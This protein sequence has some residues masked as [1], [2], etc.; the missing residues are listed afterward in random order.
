MECDEQNPRK[1]PRI[2][3]EEDVINLEQEFNFEFDSFEAMIEHE[4]STETLLE[5]RL[6]IR[7]WFHDHIQLCSI[8]GFLY[9]Y[10]SL[11]IRKPNTPS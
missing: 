3:I 7:W 2:Y 9:S 6:Q 5:G 11:F 4:H 1:N 10:G 8:L